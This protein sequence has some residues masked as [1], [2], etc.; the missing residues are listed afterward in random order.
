MAIELEKKWKAECDFCNEVE[1]IDERFLQEATVEEYLD[2]K[3]WLVD[4]SLGTCYCCGECYVKD[5]LRS[6]FLKELSRGFTWF[7]DALTPC[8]HLNKEVYAMYLQL[9]DTWVINAYASW[10]FEVLLKLKKEWED[11]NRKL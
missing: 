2:A 4:K 11:F 10:D 8:V 6:D 5:F 7:K 9:S 3:C 1:Q